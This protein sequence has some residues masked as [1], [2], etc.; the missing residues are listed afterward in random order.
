MSGKF[1]HFWN[2]AALCALSNAKDLFWGIAREREG[3][4]AGT[5]GGKMWDWACDA[6][7]LPCLEVAA[8]TVNSILTLPK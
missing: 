5:E 1:K 6:C 7:S 4:R 8:T 2:L 3:S